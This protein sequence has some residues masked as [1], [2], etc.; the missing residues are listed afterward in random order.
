MAR[1]VI[2]AMFAS[3]LTAFSGCGWMSNPYVGEEGL[4][5]LHHAHSQDPKGLDPVR[6]SD[7]LTVG[8]VSQIYDSLYQYAYLERPFKLEPALAADMADISED[9]LTYTIPIKKGIHFQ[10]DPCFVATGGKGRELT[11]EDFIYSWK[12]VA[13]VN[14]NPDGYWVFKGYIVGMDQFHEASLEARKNK[15]EM[16]CSKDIEGLKALDRYTLQIKLTKPYPRLLW[17]LA[18]CYTAAVPRE[19]VEYYG[20]EFLNHPVGTGAFRLRRWD[21][22]HKLVLE[23]NPTYRD[24]FYPTKGEPGD[25]E[26]GFLE[27]AGKKLPLA[28]RV[29][30]T[31]IKQEQPSWLYFLSGHL[32][33][34]G[35]PKDSWNSA[36]TSLMNLTPEMQKK[37]IRL[38]FSRGGYSIGYIAFN[39]DDSTVGMKYP[40]IAEKEIGEKRK[41]AEEALK[42][43]EKEA[44][45]AEAEG[46]TD[47]AREIRQQAAEKAGKLREEA[48]KLEKELPLL[49]EK[50]A[51][52]LKLRRA[53]SLAVNREQRIKIFYNG[54]AYVA[55]GPIPPAVNGYDPDFRNPLSRYDVKQAKKLL[56]Q[57]GYPGGIGPDGERLT[58]NYDTTG[59]STWTQQMADFFRLEM[60]EIGINVKITSNTWTE[61]LNKIRDTRA[62]VYYVGWYAD[63]PDAEN[64]L[65][66]FYG[67]KKS[68]GPNNSNYHNPEYDRL[69][70]EMA[71][72]SDFDPQEAG[73]K[74][75]LCRKMEE[76]VTRDCPWVFL[77]NS[78]GPGLR[79]AWTGLSKPH[80]FASNILKYNKVDPELRHKLVR[81]WNQPTL[82]PA[83]AVLALVLAMAGLFVYK[84][85]KQGE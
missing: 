30:Y 20:E 2:F 8:L 15:Q 40:E 49:P 66:L 65:L 10:D 64:F 52:R 27:D 26:E 4:M 47:Q 6:T 72:L 84:L 33:S 9:K 59:T 22:W 62:Q 21:H 71:V 41:A 63:Y 18:M 44:K 13:D 25:A 14:N 36:I 11:A 48:D 3:L 80:E 85:M 17:I 16:D 19:A 28:D 23:R 45:K 57:A 74:Y 82:W 39:M 37:G 58:L 32:D 34:S 42:S 24:D 53:I 61:F 29:V 69:Y 83:F 60:R 55:N 7:S 81:Q 67:P 46:E 70:D 35:V 77:Q 51:R 5:V 54:C 1:V 76:I 50:N 43:A 68:P 75:E 56:A 38:R 12:R 79:H 73:R 78:Y 31:I